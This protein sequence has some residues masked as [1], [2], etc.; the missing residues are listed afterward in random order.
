M[1]GRLDPEENVM[2]DNRFTQDD[3]WHMMS[4]LGWD[5]RNDE[6]VIDVG[7]VAISG[8]DVGEEY[9]KKWQSPKGTVK[10]NKDAFL[11]I[12]NL[13]RTPFEPSQPPETE[14]KPHHIKVAEQEIA[15]QQDEKA[16]AAALKKSDDEKGYDTYSK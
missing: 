8:I 7:G 14:L 16:I 3:L 5:V 10:Y 4:D 9:N 13:S 11:V 1:H 2:R 12:K 15:I 6:I